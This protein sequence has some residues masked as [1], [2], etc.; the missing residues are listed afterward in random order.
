MLVTVKRQ[1]GPAEEP[2]VQ[3]FLYTGE[4]GRRTVMTLLRELNGRAPL[5]DV[6]GR[7]AE[8]I[9]YECS[10]SQS[11]CG[12]C[13]MRINGRPTLACAAFLQDI[14]GD[15]LTL[16]PLSR[17]PV[18]RDLCVDRDVIEQALCRMD[19][20]TDASSPVHASEQRHLYAVGRCLRCGLCLE[21][22]PPYGTDGAVLGAPFI[23]ELYRVCAEEPSRREALLGA[24]EYH[25][26][27]GCIGEHACMSVCPVHM[28]TL[29]SFAKLSHMMD[30]KYK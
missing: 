23:N 22:C 3:T 30:E 17:F 28:P 20:F 29:A 19:V 12:A 26:T 14:E 4:R 6:D 25:V 5:T 13:A 21:A 10:C 18:I 7:P 24:L 8:P 9:A 2:Y 16:E 27:Q 15:E 1:R 11:T